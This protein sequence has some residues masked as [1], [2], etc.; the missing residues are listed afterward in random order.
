M[1]FPVFE[2]LENTDR[3][4]APVEYGRIKELAEAVRKYGVSANFT[5]A[6]LDRLAGD[7]MTPT[8]WQTVAKAT[9]LSMGQYLE[10]KALWH[11]A[12][13]DQAR[14]NAASLTPEQQQ[15]T[16]DMLT[17][18]GHYAANQTNYPWGVYQQI[19]STAIRAWKALSKRGEGSNQLT[20]IIQGTQ[21]PFSDFVARMTEAAGRIF[22]DSEATMPFIEQLIFEQATQE[23]CTAI[24][25]RKNKGLQDW[26]RVCRE[27]GGP[28]TNAG[29]AAAILQSQKRPPRGP[30]R[31]VC[32][33]C[34]K[35]GHMKR[36]CKS[37]KNSRHFVS[38]V[39]KDTIK[40]INVAQ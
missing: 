4:Y 27:L 23:C 13:Q 38:G 10:W 20:K 5:L 39:A 16:F 1:S 7:A 28:L 14:A 15:W 18:Q 30:D 2:S 31:R 33:N 3:A 9:L 19:S 25:S 22:G 17:G 6:Q 8:D 40:L 11:E 32:F 29:L 12:A 35:P 37:Q 36:D 34:G 24:A 26:L 21:E